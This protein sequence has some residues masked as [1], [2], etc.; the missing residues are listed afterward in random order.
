MLHIKP[1]GHWSFGSR[2][3]DIS[4][5]K[6][7]CLPSGIYMLLGFYHIWALRP[8]WPCDPDK[9][10]ILLLPLHIKAPCKILL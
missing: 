1:E 8:F 5:F 9:A 6:R 3:E 10:N 4:I 2:E 7:Y